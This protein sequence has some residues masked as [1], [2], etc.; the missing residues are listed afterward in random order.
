MLSLRAIRT[1]F[2][3][4]LN[5]YR[6]NF[7]TS[8]ASLRNPYT[9]SPEYHLL[10]TVYYH[11]RMASSD[12]PSHTDTQTPPTET[13]SADIPKEVTATSA[14]AGTVD[15]SNKLHVEEVI[16]NSETV[17]TKD[18]DATPPLES[19]E[20]VAEK[21]AEKSSESETALPNE[22]ETSDKPAEASDSKSDKPAETSD[23]KSDKPAETPDS[24]SDKKAETSDS[25]SDK[26]AET[27][28]PDS[29]S[30]KKAVAT[31]SPNPKSS[32]QPD[33][34]VVQKPWNLHR[35]L[36]TPL[37]TREHFESL[38]LDK[39]RKLYKCGSRYAQLKDVDTW[40]A[41]KVAHKCSSKY[42]LNQ[43]IKP[44]PAINSKLSLWRGDITTLEIDSIVNAANHTLL[45]GG[46]V[47]GAIH[48]AAGRSLYRE[49]HSLNGCE[50]GNSKISGGHK[51]PAKYIIHT[52][53][54]IGE[55]ES[56]LISCYESCLRLVEENNL[57][58]IAFCCISTGIYG[59]PN[60]KAAKTALQTVRNWFDTSEYAKTQMERVIFCVFLKVDFQIYSDLMC[61]FFPTP[62]A[63]PIP[64]TG[65]VG[66]KEGTPPIE[67][68]KPISPQPPTAVPPLKSAVT[69][70][71][72]LIA[73]QLAPSEGDTGQEERTEYPQ[74]THGMSEVAGE[75]GATAREMERVEP[76]AKLPKLEGE[77]AVSGA[78]SES[79]PKEKPTEPMEDRDI[80]EKPTE[81]M[82][83]RDIQEKPTEPMEDRD[84]QDKLTEP[85]E[86]RDIQD[87]LNEPMEDRDIQ[88]KPT[89]PMEDRDIQE[90]PTEPME[91]RDTQEK[92]TEPMEDRD[93]QEKPTEPMEDRD[94][95]EKPTEPMEDRD[96]QDST[97][98]V[99][100]TAEEEKSI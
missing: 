33:T 66:D 6:N 100:P 13:D 70:P 58:S 44:D 86:D 5:P 65:K 25:K 12:P 23:S 11:R 48:D 84:T 3:L 80:Q 32:P 98:D 76:S 97:T 43:L 34:K 77:D 79:A 87:K 95:Q 29:K 92:P 26:K 47:D 63:A 36:T 53:G 68:T 27:P 16:T 91:D 89:E 67:D 78:E 71:A 42:K 35:A 50:T 40:P 46:G 14:D 10:Q 99:K 51:L 8:T 17:S 4:N 21:P 55:R 74:A 15:N 30:D 85:M 81:P 88:E 7:L 62:P 52:V 18:R 22:T 19:P 45:G 24:K 90:K 83:D 38:P 57:K 73:Q 39:K 94:T 75:E 20:D 2:I 69:A 56:L 93:I 49:C 31:A 9:A 64:N 82:E 61:N 72:A 41:F 28:V 60:L 1:A 37:E 59:Y 96:T 54:P